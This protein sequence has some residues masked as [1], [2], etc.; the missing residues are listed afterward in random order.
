[1][2]EIILETK[3]LCKQ[4][5]KQTVLKNINMRI[6]KGCVYGL[7]GA[8]GAGKSTLM[9]IL[10]GMTRAAAGK[11]QTI[12][13]ECE[14]LPKWICVN[15]KLLIRSWENLVY[16]AIEYTPQGGMIRICISEGKE[17]LEISVEDERRMGKTA[18]C[19]RI[20]EI[21]NCKSLKNDIEYK[22]NLI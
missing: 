17:Q 1:M 13:F 9:K 3:E 12:Q 21:S 22:R 2:E 4:Y 11:K 8:N 10:C 6:P 18:D 14:N 5:H 7:L 19:E 20:P 16:N 15:E